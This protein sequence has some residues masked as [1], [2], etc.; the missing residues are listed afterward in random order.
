VGCCGLVA[1]YQAR[2]DEA[3]LAALQRRSPQLSMGCGSG[4]PTPV[5]APRARVKLSLAPADASKLAP[6]ELE[7]IQ[8]TLTGPA[9]YCYAKAVPERA[10]HG[11]VRLSLEF[12]V[13]GTVTASSI[14]SKNE[15]PQALLDCLRA[16]AARL[17]LARAAS[18]RSLALDLELAPPKP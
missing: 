17:A 14:S 6:Q 5:T 2:H 18:P 16:A 15:P 12:G 4:G 10:F 11:K 3:R 8:R 13:E 7:L 9:N 1:I